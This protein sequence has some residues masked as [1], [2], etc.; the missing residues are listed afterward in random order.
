M[1]D[2]YWQLLLIGIGAA[3]G[4]LM[5]LFLIQRRTGDATA[6][7]AGWGVAIALQAAI[8]G[9]L[10]P[11]RVEHRTLIASVAG[12]EAL[13]VAWVVVRRLGQGEDSRYR[14]LRER[15]RSWGREQLTFF[16][17]YH[18][19]GLLAVVL[20]TPVLLACFNRHRGLEPV[21][22]AGAGLWLVALVGQTVADRQLRRFKADPA[23]RGKTMRYGLWRYSRHP[24]YFF[25]WLAWISYGLIAVAAPW[26]WLGFVS[27]PLILFLMLF[28]TGI[29]P[30]EEQALKRRAD[31]TD[32]QRVTS[33]FVPWLPRKA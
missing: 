31:Y 11:G 14:E 12:S 24:N 27:A 10:G 26:G 5:V 18:A 25:Q 15:W 28:V 32:Y 16:V 23:N 29:P 17:F 4:L 9:A 6:V 2:S 21:E 3:D 8:Y 30:S 1:I 22:W 19:Q 20:S 33:A 13:R 7:D